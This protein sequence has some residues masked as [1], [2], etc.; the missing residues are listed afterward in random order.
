MIVA[1]IMQATIMVGASIGVAVGG[2]ALVVGVGGAAVVGAIQ[3][4]GRVSSMMVVGAIMIVGAA[5][6]VGRAIMVEGAGASRRLCHADIALVVAIFV[7]EGAKLHRSAG[8]ARLLVSRLRG[9]ARE[10]VLAVV[11]ASRLVVPVVGA[12]V[13]RQ[14]AVRDGRTPAVMDHMM[15]NVM[16]S[17]RVRNNIVKHLAGDGATAED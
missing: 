9:L 7:R 13:V 15:D 11:A 2:A 8:S 1:T 3:A 6:V 16:D 17:S 14:P 12:V 10:L 5:M 4:E